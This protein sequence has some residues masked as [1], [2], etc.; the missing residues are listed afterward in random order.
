MGLLASLS[1]FGVAL[2]NA[3]LAVIFL[4]ASVFTFVLSLVRILPILLLSV[5][6]IGIAYIPYEY[7]DTI[8]EN[9]AYF[10][11]CVWTPFYE[12]WVAPVLEGII[13]VS[14]DFTIC[15]WDAW[16]IFPYAV[17]RQVIFPTV[18]DCGFATTM[19]LLAELLVAVARDW[20]VGYVA[21]GDWFTQTLD[22]DDIATAWIALW[23][24][25]QGMACC[26]CMDLC[27][28]FVDLPMIP[29][30]FTTSQF[31]DPAWSVFVGDS[32]NGWMLVFQELV[33]M[34][35]KF[36]YPAQP[37]VSATPT[38]RRSFDLWCS[39][40][41]AFWTSWENALQNTWDSFIPYDFVWR[42]VLA[43]MHIWTCITL[44]SINL[45]MDTSFNGGAVLDHFR[46]VDSTYWTGTVRAEFTEIINM[47][48]TAS[49]FNTISVTLPGVGNTMSI[50]TY[51][52]PPAQEAVP[53]IGGPNPLFG[54]TTLSA[55]ACLSIKRLMC[56]PTDV[57]I[58]CAEQFNGTVLETFNF[59]CVVEEGW[60]VDFLSWAFEFTLHVDSTDDFVAFLDGQPFST[61][62]TADWVGWV[63]CVAEIFLVVEQ[64]GEC[65]RTVITE[66][67][68][69]VLSMLNLGL[70]VATTSLLL[71]YYATFMPDTLNFLSNDE[72]LV[73]ALAFLDRVTAETPDSLINCLC[74]LLNNG[75]AVPFAGCTEVPCEP[76]G[77]V[78]P[79]VAQARATLPQ[80]LFR[81]GFYNATMAL[82]GRTGQYAHK[83]NPIR[84]YHAGQRVM[85]GT[86]LFGALTTRNA[87]A[88]A[89]NVEPWVDDSFDSFQGAA[90]GK[91]CSAAV[92][93]NR[94]RV[95]AS[96][97]TETIVLDCN[98]SAVPPPCFNLC[99]LPKALI[100]F[101]AQS[102]AFGARFLQAA[103]DTNNGTGS[104]YFDG[105]A[106][107]AGDP[108]LAS[109]ATAWFVNLIKPLNCVCQFLNLVIPPTQGFPDPCCFFTYTGELLSCMAQILI[110]VG[111]SMA[112]DPTYAYI[113]DPAGLQADLDVVFQIIIN[114]FDCACGFIRVIFNIILNE[115]DLLKNFDP[116]CIPLKLLRAAVETA[117]WFVQISI[118]FGTIE[119]TQG[120]C[121]F[122]IFTPDRPDCVVGIDTLPF[123]V[124]FDHIL[125]VL[126]TR[127]DQIP[128]GCDAQNLNF[129]NPDTEGLPTCI[130]KLFNA[131]L[132][133]I[134]APDDEG[135]PNKC[136]IDLCCP[137]YRV[138]ILLDRA[139][140][141]TIRV[142]GTLW[143]N[144]EIKVVTPPNNNPIAANVPVDFIDAFFCDEY[145][146]FP[147]P[148][149]LVPGT[150]VSDT[151]LCLEFEPV[152]QAL[153][154]LMSTCICGANGGIGTVMDDILSWFL[155]FVSEA[156]SFTGL[157]KVQVWPNCLCAGGPATATVR[158]V[159]V[160]FAKLVSTG[161]RQA[162]IM[163]RN[164]PNPNYWA[165]EIGA[166]IYNTDYQQELVDNFEDV[167]RS[168]IW[169]T[170]EPMVGAICSL[171]TNSLCFLNMILG[172][173]CEG[174]RYDIGSSVTTYV[175]KGIVHLV[176]LAEG[177]VKLIAVE[178][179]GQCV[180]D[181]DQTQ[182][183]GTG[184]FGAGVTTTCSQTDVDRGTAFGVLNGNKLGS[185]F[186]ALTGFVVDALI[187]TAHL[188]CT[189]VCPGKLLYA[190]PSPGTFIGL[191][192]ACSCWNTSP[193]RT[194]TGA[195]GNQCNSTVCELNICRRC[196]AG[197]GTCVPGNGGTGE[198]ETIAACYP[199]VAES[200]ASAICPRGCTNAS[201]APTGISYFPPQTIPWS[202]SPPPPFVPITQNY[203][204]TFDA[205]VVPGELS[206]SIPN[207]SPVDVKDRAMTFYG[208]Q[209]AGD[210]RLYL[211]LCIRNNCVEQGLCKNDQ[212]ARCQE[213]E[214][215]THPVL[216]GV[217]RVAL[218]LLKCLAGEFV[219]VADLFS[220]ADIIDMALFLQNVA[221]QFSGGLIRFV[222]AGLVAG[223]N[224]L[225]RPL[226]VNLFLAI[227]DILQMFEAFIGMISQ[228]IIF[229]ARVVNGIVHHYLVKQPAT[230]RDFPSAPDG[231]LVEQ[232]LGSLW[233]ANLTHCVE[234]PLECICR[235]VKFTN[236]AGCE[237]DDYDETVY[238][239]G[240]TIDEV[241]T[242]VSVHYGN[243]TNPFTGVDHDVEPCDEL[244]RDTAARGWAATS[245]A[246]RFEYVNCMV[247]RVKGENLHNWWSLIPK[248]FFYSQN[249]FLTTYRTARLFFG[250]YVTRL[251]RTQRTEEQARADY[252]T[253]E[254]NAEKHQRFR[255]RMLAR[256]TYAKRVMTGKRGYKDGHPAIDFM[257]IMDS[258]WTKYTSGYYSHL[259]QR[260]ARNI[261]DGYSPFGTL[262]ENMMD[263]VRAI[264]ELHT[265]YKYIDMSE[266]KRIM[267][268]T[269]DNFVRAFGGTPRAFDDVLMQRK[270]PQQLRE[271]KHKAHTKRTFVVPPL[272]YVF[273]QLR[274]AADMSAWWKW[275]NVGD[276]IRSAVPAWRAPRVWRH[277]FR[278]IRWIGE[279]VRGSRLVRVIRNRESIKRLAVRTAYAIVPHWI[280]RDNM[281]RFVLDGNCRVV[282]GTV[283]LTAEIVDYC[284][285]DLVMNLPPRSGQGLRRYL[286]ATSHARPGTFHS[287]YRGRFTVINSTCG[288]RKQ[289]AL[290]TDRVE[291]PVRH[292]ITD[293]NVYRRATVPLSNSGTGDP[294]GF[295]LY[296]TLIGI[297][298]DLLGIDL[299]QESSD[300]Q[301]QVEEFVSNTGLEWSDVGLLYWV[302][303]SF[304]CEWP[305]SLNC[306]IRLLPTLEETLWRVG[307]VYVIALVALAITVPG[308]LS[309][310]GIL[311]GFISYIVVV[312][313][314]AW[315]FPLGCWFMW[316][317]FP[318]TPEVSLPIVPFP[319]ASITFPMCAMSDIN[320]IFRKYSTTD[321][322]FLIPPAMYNGPTNPTCP[323][324]IDIASCRYEVGMGD[325]ISNLLYIGYRV[326]GVP[327]NRWIISYIGGFIP[328]T[329]EYLSSILTGFEDASETQAERQWICFWWTILSLALPFALALPIA[330]A[331]VTFLPPLFALLQSMLLLFATLPMYDFVVHQG[332]EGQWSEVNGDAGYDE[333]GNIGGAIP[334]PRPRPR[335][336]RRRRKKRERDERRARRHHQAAAATPT[337]GIAARSVEYIM[338]LFYPKYKQV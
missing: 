11:S 101:S 144:W 229:S 56:D 132:A 71:F 277:G 258:A 245:Y 65:L 287:R 154:D 8:V 130:C 202:I 296:G 156:Q 331:L 151:T 26:G 244:V 103:Y 332:E 225:T 289:Y 190:E 230:T 269:R 292:Y 95:I 221:W 31:G 207:A 121:Y 14:F 135:D 273:S 143:Q 122:Y 100:L 238:P 322:S 306:S 137:I 160:P 115:S 203:P 24:S 112:G 176:I 42:D 302:R 182:G 117:R 16:M 256:A 34:A 262:H 270:T 74:Y 218:R 125:D 148:Q 215:L 326:F 108:C 240:I 301:K 138:G 3:G 63:G 254:F 252:Y 158:G 263:M 19:R 54:D 259:V 109:D 163:L 134:Y 45:V 222:A 271:E 186:V 15:W 64:Y 133:A 49:S 228:P 172:D 280:S 129:I 145:D 99:C 206:C 127:E 309:A 30:P 153:E 208:A 285:N 131:L 28:V 312:L 324:R 189:V 223:F 18:R 87:R 253:R 80:L 184:S 12:A 242:A 288:R 316:P 336:R 272:P 255:W 295:S 317:T 180:G 197:D 171:V 338:G 267:G 136:P 183:V 167:E 86:A 81:D 52:L 116:C 314:V 32:F 47:I 257:V 319:I 92:R 205:T 308:V 4:I 174:L 201:L 216:D 188:G 328:G 23:Q 297:I 48:D 224:F 179:P 246:Q 60:I 185:I 247:Q 209:T 204:W 329:Y 38:F 248:N 219:S 321:Y 70:R 327:F 55:A 260:A 305:E 88:F 140:R 291:H 75:F 214:F 152:I 199:Q 293:R 33:N 320:A 50:R 283:K 53:V 175:L 226:F 282:D 17:V 298:G 250:H 217:I 118:S 178:P 72:A 76:T 77:Y 237:Y 2:V 330:L 161:I 139:A 198:W 159:F 85:D 313:A 82:Q 97:I 251:S 281:E 211:T 13:Q 113:K 9:L 147:G 337:A 279:P 1:Y 44:R 231:D 169:R 196:Q 21:S 220:L 304:V 303:F 94:A 104:R 310:M 173:K 69:Y 323:E 276:A 119:T 141:F 261:G 114:M 236:G 96:N 46:A 264:R 192:N 90:N 59:C 318:I 150:N 91:A 243:N 120:E 275:G 58:T 66:S 294:Y 22:Y 166:N 239:E 7:G 200:L 62:I 102:T 155:P 43:P 162:A 333:Y 164:L 212:L 265:T 39:A 335:E 227:P 170:L 232:L 233:G 10:G 278:T 213:D 73:E 61:L 168:W 37:N 234:K 315:H 89:A 78:D 128:A 36:L 57:G 146:L 210:G 98:N 290:S 107:E 20:L 149:G 194:V 6:L 325:G 268:R 157:F 235:T 83:L 67:I 106:C 41:V 35:L 93:D 124:Q 266:G 195:G 110:N 165:P 29:M 249:A 300:I 27:P 126:V 40:S 105:R 142:A 274:S 191:P 79:N 284:L 25:W 5:G 181:P 123:I 177:L 84:T 311:L 187:G 241:L 193:Y 286:A 51:A 299:A 307:L 68:N 111:N 334:Q